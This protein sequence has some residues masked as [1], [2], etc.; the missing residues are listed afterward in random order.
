MTSRL[1]LVGEK[2]LCISVFWGPNHK[3]TALE[4]TDP[5]PPLGFEYKGR[6]E[7]FGASQGDLSKGYWHFLG[8]R[9]KVYVFF[10]DGTYWKIL[11]EKYPF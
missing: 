5:P 7:I 2:I 4:E 11:M 3:T 10:F 8:V 1:K 6:K 9:L